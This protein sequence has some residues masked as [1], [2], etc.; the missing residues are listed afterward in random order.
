MKYYTLLLCTLFLLVACKSRQGSNTSV[1]ISEDIPYVQMDDIGE[2]ETQQSHPLPR[3]RFKKI[4]APMREVSTIWNPFEKELSSFSEAKYKSMV[5]YVL[6]KSIPEIQEAIRYGIFTYEQLTLFYIYRIYTYESNPQTRLNAIISLNPNAV[7][8]ARAK[9]IAFKDKSLKHP[10]FGMPILLKDNINFEGI[11]TTAG[12]A[13]LKD[14]LG[15]DA[16]ITSQLKAHGAIILGKSNLSEWA[17]FMCEGCPLG[18][19]AMG[20]QTLNPYGRKLFESG[21]SSSGSGVATAAN[22]AVATVGSETSGFI[23]SPSSLNS[24]VGLKPTVGVLS[25]SGIV[26]ISSFLD[27]PGPMTKNVTDNAILL[28]AMLG[29][30][31]ADKA[32]DTAVY[33]PSYQLKESSTLKGKRLGVFSSLMSDSIY[34]EVINLMR[35]EGAEIVVMDPKPTSLNGFL[36]L[37]TADMKRDLPWYLKNYTGKNVKVRSVEDVVGFNRKDSLLYMPY[38]QG[39]FEGIVSDTTSLEE[40]EDVKASLKLSGRTFFNSLMDSNTF[41]AILSINNFHASY[42]AVAHYPC[43]TVPMGYKNNGE[44]IGLTFIAKP[45]QELVLLELGYAFERASNARKIPV[46]YKN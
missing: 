39:L 18:Y 45:Y 19:S 16:F 33:M 31:K 29:K 6:E 36:T 22:Y 3:M 23:L 25:R 12:A 41:D 4:N 9:D 38:G 10:I 43:L 13:V 26:P 20:G 28:S 21:G 2:I 34:N 32:T 27:T 5:P 44:P 15:K 42:A 11:P 1:E 37:L 7:R 46:L 24:I 14:N 35:R 30:D 8:E 17:Y 40:L